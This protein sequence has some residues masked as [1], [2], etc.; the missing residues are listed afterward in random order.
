MCE[1]HQAILTVQIHAAV[2]SIM[3]DA[4]KENV[5]HNGVLQRISEQ[6]SR[7]DISGTKKMASNH[8]FTA[9]VLGLSR[10]P[11]VIIQL[12]RPISWENKSSLQFS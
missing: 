6:R 11:P 12:R 9:L 7:A 1:Y 10:I 4:S 5:V 8:R 2:N 3:E